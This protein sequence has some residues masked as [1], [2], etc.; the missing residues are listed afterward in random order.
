MQLRIFQI[1]AFTKTVFNGNPAAVCLLES[2]L[3]DDV[4]QKIALENNLS[5]TAFLVKSDKSEKGYDL[6]W[7]TPTTEVDLCGHATLASAW[8]LINEYNEVASPLCFMTRSGELRVKR[9]GQDLIMDFPLQRATSC[10]VPAQLLPS[11]GLQSAEV[12]AAE[13]YL[14]VVENE[15]TV[16]QL[17]PD[18]T[19]LQGLPLRGVMVTAPGE[20]VDFVSRWFGPNVGVD[21]DPVTGSS[22]TTLAPYWSEKLG[23]NELTARQISKRSCEL[24]CRVEQERVFITGSAV[25][26]ME[27]MTYFN[28]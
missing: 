23:K 21:E 8:V 17:Q 13:D 9:S 24:I 28:N 7:F 26:Y 19:G 16:K 12:L 20:S 2:W 1:D 4:L 18:F 11:L 3:D 22:H 15:Q 6:R 14:V 10:T 5:E 25:K 27:G